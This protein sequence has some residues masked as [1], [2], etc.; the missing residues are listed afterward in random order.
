MTT[1]IEQADRNRSTV[2]AT[3]YGERPA[4]KKGECFYCHALIGDR[5]FVG[6][7]CVSRRATVRLTIEFDMDIWTGES[8]CETRDNFEFKWNEGT[9]CTSNLL[10]E[11]NEAFSGAVCACRSSNV[12][13]LSMHGE[14]RE[15]TDS[16][17]I[18]K[19]TTG[20]FA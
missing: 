17:R 7:P 9:A 14:E 8:E 6:C 2:V 12:K 11:V 18:T 16:Y 13:V 15:A 19:P 1:I 5:H 10:H 4:G 3:T 20:E